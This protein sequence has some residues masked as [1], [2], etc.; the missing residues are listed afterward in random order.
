MA[1]NNTNLFGTDLFGEAVKSIS[2]GPVAEKFL[3]SPFTVLDARGKNWQDRKKAW[4]RLG[5]KSEIGR[6]DDLLYNKQM[7]SFDYYRVK[8]GKQKQTTVQQTS[9]FDPLLCE[10]SYKWF[11]PESGQVVDPFAGGS[12]RGIVASIL[13]YN[14]W[15]CDLSND[16]IIAN[17][18]Q[19][20]KILDKNSVADAVWIQGDS[21]KE[22]AHAPQA[23]F[24]FSCPPYGNLEKYSD[25]PDDLSNMSYEDFVEVY[26]DIIKKSIDGLKPNRFACFVVGDFRDKNGLYRNFVSETIEAFEDAGARLYNEAILVSVIASAS[27]RVTK[28]FDASRKLCKTHQNV[29][30]FCKGD[31]KKAAKACIG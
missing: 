29:L 9:I 3:V 24:I 2:A 22:L 26:R 8:E 21:N 28:Q 1:E 25:D 18:E 11:C 16:Q 19:K 4:I 30:V 13:G 17:Y 27:M 6:G 14:Y 23:D 20:S 12:V 5:I 31:W 7:G 15:G 10:I